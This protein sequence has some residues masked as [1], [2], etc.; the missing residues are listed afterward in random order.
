VKSFFP[1]SNFHLINIADNH[2][3]GALICLSP[4]KFLVN[5]KYKNIKDILPEK[6]KNWDFIFPVETTRKTSG[7]RLASDEGMDINILTPGYI[8]IIES[9][10]FEYEFVVVAN[11]T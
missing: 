10:L 4:G 8:S 11:K 6:F 3:D 2:I 1:E 5:P 7:Q 9:I